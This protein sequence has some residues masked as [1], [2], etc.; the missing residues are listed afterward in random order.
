MLLGTT[1]TCTWAFKSSQVVCWSLSDMLGHPKTPVYGDLGMRFNSQWSC[2]VSNTKIN[3]IFLNMLPLT[4]WQD[5]FYLMMAWSLWNLEFLFLF[6]QIRGMILYTMK[7][8]DFFIVSIKNIR[9]K[10]QTPDERHSV[11]HQYREL[12]TIVQVHTHIQSQ[13]LQSHC[14]INKKVVLWLV[15]LRI[16]SKEQRE[17]FLLFLFYTTYCTKAAM[18]TGWKLCCLHL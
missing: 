6:L 3:H 18:E 16:K 13:P 8:K 11:R 17:T 14:L 12:Y 10:V 7:C 5:I 15:L 1:E 4:N 2:V 9:E